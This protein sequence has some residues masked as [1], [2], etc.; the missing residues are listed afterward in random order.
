[1]DQQEVQ[2]EVSIV[3]IFRRIGQLSFYI[4]VGVAII[5]LIE[6]ILLQTTDIRALT[7]CWPDGVGVSWVCDDIPFKTLRQIVLSLPNIFIWAPIVLFAQAFSVGLPVTPEAFALLMI[8]DLILLF[9]AIHVFRRVLELL[10]LR[11]PQ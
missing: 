1:M 6:M 9:A 7:G 2:E 11:Q 3:P 4:V 5:F 8:A 10:K